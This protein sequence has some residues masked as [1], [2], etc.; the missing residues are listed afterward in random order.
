MRCQLQ[1]SSMNA[2]SSS[3][4]ARLA[5]GERSARFASIASRGERD[6]LGGERLAHAHRTVASKSPSMVQRLDRHGHA[7]TSIHRDARRRARRRP[8]SRA[9]VAGV[10]VADHAHA[11]V[12]GEHPLQLLGGEVGAVGDARPCPAW[13][14]RP[15]PTPPPWWMLTH[16]A[17]AARVDEG[18]EQRPVGDRVGPVEPSPRSRGRARRPSPESRWSRPI[19]IGAYSSPVRTISLKRSPSRWRSP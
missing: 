13:I 9:L 16:V 4:L 8:R 3:A 11:R 10:G 1:K 2:P 7:S 19:T 15:M 6:L 17:P 14:E 5:C 12:V 18:V